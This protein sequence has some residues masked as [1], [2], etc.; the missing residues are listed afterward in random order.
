MVASRSSRRRARARA[1]ARAAESQP[2]SRARP[3]TSRSSWRRART[4]RRPQLGAAQPPSHEPPSRNS[5]P[6]HRNH[7]TR[8]AAEPPH[9]APSRRP[10]LVAAQGAAVALEDD[11]RYHEMRSLNEVVGY[12]PPDHF[13][14]MKALAERRLACGA[15]IGVLPKEPEPGPN[16]FEAAGSTGFR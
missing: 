11:V 16:V 6:P 3:R 12:C 8:R 4:A 13:V 9:Y 1:L 2:H 5:A 15:M 7:V 10:Q 14:K